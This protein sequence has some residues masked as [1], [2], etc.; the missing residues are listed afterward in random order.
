MWLLYLYVASVGSAQVCHCAAMDRHHSDRGNQGV[1]QLF[2]PVL[3]PLHKLGHL[4]AVLALFPFMDSLMWVTVIR[5]TLQKETKLD[6][7]KN[8]ICWENNSG[9]RDSYCVYRHDI[10]MTK[11][12]QE[13]SVRSCLTLKN[14]HF[15]VVNFYRNK[16]LEQALKIADCHKY[17]TMQCL[18]YFLRIASTIGSLYPNRLL[19]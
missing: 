5:W 8:K 19:S 6:K 9:E 15:K 13:M 4:Q 14:I 7:K 17:S 1:C 2:V 16:N 3:Q 11:C 10:D 18:P 12:S